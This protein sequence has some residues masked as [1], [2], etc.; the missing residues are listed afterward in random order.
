MK[1]IFKEKRFRDS[2]LGVILS[3]V[4]V[5]ESY[6]ASGYSVTVRQLY[7]QMIAKDLFPDSW[8]DAEYNSKNGLPPDTKNTVR[9]YSKFGNLISDARMAGLIDW[10][11]IEDR[12]RKTV[13]NTHWVSHEQILKAAVDSWAIDKWA[14]QDCHV[15]VLCEKDAVSGII[16]PVCSRHDVSFTACR[17]YS[18]Q[19][20]MYRKGKQF[21]KLMDD[22]KCVVLL[23]FGDHD[24]SGLD[25]DRDILE[26]L[27]EFSR[28]AKDSFVF[29]R[30]ALSLDQIEEYNPPPN[31]AKATDSR[32]KAY[33]KRFGKESWELDALSPEVLEALVSS[34][35]KAVRDESKW[36]EMVEKEEVTREELRRRVSL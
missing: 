1:E 30:V 4:K 32:F 7:Y 27:S 36:M 17:G 22:G 8:I 19:S 10:D 25:M 21:K 24:P 28:Y 18:S 23:Y 33:Q 13:S 12:I 31:P 9:S 2:S 35:I 3:A 20:L 34:S 11:S 29:L 16:E 14:N 5:L 26:R 6:M 15:E